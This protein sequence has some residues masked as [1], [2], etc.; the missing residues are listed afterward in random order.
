MNIKSVDKIDS[1]SAKSGD[2]EIIFDQ[3]RQ[4]L[5]YSDGKSFTEIGAT[6]ALDIYDYQ[7]NFSVDG[8]E[9]INDD[10]V[11]KSHIINKVCSSDFC[12]YFNEESKECREKP[13]C[14]LRILELI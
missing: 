8:L 9:T 14:P 10:Y 4:K 6:E 2:G 13:H 3:G 12:P 7:S 11:S 1:I 5:Y